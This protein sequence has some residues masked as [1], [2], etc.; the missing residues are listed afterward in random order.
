MGGRLLSPSAYPAPWWGPQPEGPGSAKRRRIEEPA[1]LRGARGPAS[2]PRSPRAG[3]A[4]SLQ[5]PAG[6]PA[7]GT[8]T[9]VVV[10]AP[11]CALQLPL[12]DVD[13]VLE[14]E[15]TSVLQVSLGG[16]TLLLVPEALLSPG[17]QRSGGQAHAP[18]CQEPGALQGASAEDVAV[19]QGFFRA[20]GP[21]IAVLEE[22]YDED[23]DAGPEF[24]T[25]W[26][27]A[28]A[29]SVAGF[30]PY[31]HSP[32]RE[33]SP[34]AS[35]PSPLRRSPGPYVNLDFHLLEPLPSSP[36]QLLPPSPSPGPHVRPQR[37]PGP[38]RK[39]RRRLFQE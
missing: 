12:D 24:L 4:P 38:A 7:A 39:A 14:P 19:H 3:T 5:D 35:T 27:D 33:P 32:V 21:G 6:P 1:G 2:E 31:P 34:Q 9:S 17:D 8:L 23:E 22:A 13:L 15:P 16:H 25:P 10:L 30:R 11:G 20:C 29:G 26:V 18:H 37:P 36:L 28:A